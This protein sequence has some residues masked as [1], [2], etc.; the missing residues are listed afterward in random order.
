[1]SSCLAISGE[2]QLRHFGQFLLDHD[3]MLQSLNEND[4]R[5]NFYRNSGKP[6][7]TKCAPVALK[8]ERDEHLSLFQLANSKNTILNKTVCVFAQLCTEVRELQKQSEELQLHF[9]FLDWKLCGSDGEDLAQPKVITRTSEM[10]RFFCDIQYLVQRCMIVGSDVLRQLGAF[11]GG[12]IAYI[13]YKGT[14]CK[15]CTFRF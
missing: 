10:L 14:Q 4:D 6:E 3:R 9:L 2:S 8:I 12:K 11:F 15:C 5:E 7:A 1:M 13:D